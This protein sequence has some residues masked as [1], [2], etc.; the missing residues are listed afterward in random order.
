MTDA[1]GA[2]ATPAGPATDRAATAGTAGEALAA[3]L[4]AHAAS[5]LRGLPSIEP[6]TLRRVAG[7]LHTFD[8]LL[9][10][11]WARELRDE[12]LRLD[13]L[14][15]QEQAYTRRLARLT[16][17]LDS[18]ACVDSDAA[19]GAPKARALLERQLTLARSRA[20]SLAL[21]E[22]GSA[23]FHAV[24]D[25]MTLLASD[26][27]LRLPAGS[28]PARALLTHAAAAR[29]RLAEAVAVLPLARSARPYNGDGL[30]LPDE[31]L[32]WREVR[33]LALRARYAMEVCAPLLGPEA[34]GPL[35]G[36]TELGRLLLRHEEA[37]DAAEA[38][39]LAGATARIT[40]A[41]AY[42]L[43]VVHADQRL[44]VEAARHAF[45]LAW[46]ELHHPDW[47]SDSWFT[48]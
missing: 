16:T 17:A 33:L 12:L 36:L 25:R 9:D 26:L 24:A 42:V 18:L 5:F 7:A 38:A 30:H 28:A 2:L 8:A 23:R 43:G 31:D 4:A 40:P 19:P 29:R 37:T 34:A 13:T 20:H 14:V 11:A 1:L 27:P 35:A 3:H 32:P 21:Q 48:R 15:G 45:G 41:T 22:L 46:P 44:E 39:A 10:L 47:L 6:R